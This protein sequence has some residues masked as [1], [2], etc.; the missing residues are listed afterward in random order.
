MAISIRLDQTV[1]HTLERVAKQEGMSISALVRNLLEQY[2]SRE[3]INESS[4]E[5][6]KSYF[7]Q[8]GSNRKDRSAN[9]KT[10]LK[11]KLRNKFS[12][13]KS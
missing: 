5:I 11:E 6:G 13:R 7:G 3:N 4:Y 12:K 2:L 1:E 10:L 9:Y 8:F